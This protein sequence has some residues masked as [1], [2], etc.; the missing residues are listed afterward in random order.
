MKIAIVGAGIAGP[1]LA[2]WLWR[3]GHEPTLIEKAPRLR[4]GGYVVDFWGDGYAV[5]ERMG[6]VDELHATGYAVD[7]VRLVDRNSREVGG[8]SVDLFRRNLNGRFV[9][10]PRG[11][12]A[13]RS[14]APSSTM[15]KPCSVKAFRPSRKTT[16][17]SGSHFGR[18]QSRDR[19]SWSSAP[20]ASTRLC[21]I[22]CSAPK[23]RLRSISA[24]EWPR[25]K[26]MAIS[27]AMNSSTWPTAHPAEWSG[28]L[29]CTAAGPCFYLFS[30]PP[31]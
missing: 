28:D 8:F 2:Y 3:Y 5:A 11:D 21:A 25:S 10:V 15:S 19:S 13:A 20:V 22:W 14:T 31:A 12:L 23:Q 27:R 4:T 16:Q 24:T 26:P 6:F 7:E 18:G 17:E 29:P 9:T 1:T 30:P